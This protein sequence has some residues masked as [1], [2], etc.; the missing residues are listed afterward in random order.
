MATREYMHTCEMR[1]WM[2]V[3]MHIRWIMLE[4]ILYGKRYVRDAH[5]RVLRKFAVKFETYHLLYL[6]EQLSVRRLYCALQKRDS[7]EHINTLEWRESERGRE[8]KSI[9]HR[10]KRATLNFRFSQSIYIHVDNNT[11][12]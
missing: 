12:T 11:S 6:D 10:I 5:S 7:G 2:C 9:E 1:M 8:R 3:C 4:L